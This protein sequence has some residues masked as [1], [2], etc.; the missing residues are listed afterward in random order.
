[1]NKFNS[2]SKKMFIFAAVIAMAF[3][4][5]DKNE[6]SLSTDAV[7]SAIT[8]K[9]ARKDVDSRFLIAKEVATLHSDGLKFA[10]NQLEKIQEL[11]P[12][13]LED[14]SESE[15]IE[16]CTRLGSDYMKQSEVTSSLLVFSNK[17]LFPETANTQVFVFTDKIYEDIL[18]KDADYGMIEEII[19]AAIKSNEFFNFTEAEQNNL[20]LSFAIFLDSYEYWAYSLDSWLSL[21]NVENDMQRMVVPKVQL[22]KIPK[23]LL[24]VIYIAHND[25]NG[26]LA[27]GVGGAIAGAVGGAITGPGV[28]VSTGAGCAGGAIGGAVVASIG[29]AVGCMI[30]GGADVPNFSDSYIGTIATPYIGIDYNFI[31]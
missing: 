24:N 25:A 18:A 9:A 4:A 8:Q 10:Y 23:W 15:L 30:T 26:G 7:D 2:I 19:E 12:N 6:I 11:Q 3:T 14:I 17:L 20:L 1:M 22:K 31:T 27:G 16:F 29:A 21:S 13:Y 5:C 28:L